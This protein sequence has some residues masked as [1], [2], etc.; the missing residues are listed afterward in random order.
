MLEDKVGDR[1]HALRNG[2]ILEVDTLNAA[3][4]AVRSRASRSTPQS[5]ASLWAIRQRPSQSV[6][7]GSRTF[8]RPAPPI[9]V[10]SFKSGVGIEFAALAFFHQIKT[11]IVCSSSRG[12]QKILTDFLHDLRGQGVVAFCIYLGNIRSRMTQRNLCSFKAKLLANCRGR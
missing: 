6:E 3:I 7:L 2:L 12:T 11:N 8:P 4:D 10:P 5:F 9:G 1:T